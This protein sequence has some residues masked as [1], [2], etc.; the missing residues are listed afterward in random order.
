MIRTGISHIKTLALFA[1]FPLTFAITA[2]VGVD[3]RPLELSAATKLAAPDMLVAS[4]A[5]TRPAQSGTTANSITDSSASMTTAVST[6]TLTVDNELGKVLGFELAVPADATVTVSGGGAVASL[7]SPY[8]I[9]EASDYVTSN[10]AENG[11][12]LVNETQV[13]GAEHVYVFQ[14]ED[15]WVSITIVPMKDDQATINFAVTE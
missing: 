1:F 3:G 10:L 6:H 9:S 14:Q 11:F 4:E 12:T 13:N 7:K 15:K 2:C 8:T 5:G